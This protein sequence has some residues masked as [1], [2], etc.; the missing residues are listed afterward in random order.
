MDDKTIYMIILFIYLIGMLAIGIWGSKK[1]TSAKSYYTSDRNVNAI[2]TGFSYSSTQLS[3]GSTIGMPATIYRQGYSYMG[4]PMS[5]AAAPW[6]TFLLTGE[7]IRKIS[8][9]V[10]AID[11]ADIFRV[12]FGDRTKILYQI[13]IIVFAIPMI[14]SQFAAAGA[15]V[16]SL[17]GIPY[18]AA[19]PLIAIVLTIYTMTGGMNSVA[20]TDYFQ[21]IIMI[22]GFGI[23]ACLL[24]TEVGGFTAMHTAI[25][26]I[27]PKK[28]TLTGYANPMWVIC[29]IFT[30]SVMMIGGG[31]TQVVRFLIPKDVR[32]LRNALGYST[33]FNVFILITCAIIGLCGISLL[34]GLKATDNMVPTLIG[35]YM[36]PV[37]G[38]ILISAVIAAIMSSVDSILLLCS[39]AAE[40]MYSSYI[41]KSAN[42]EQQLKIGRIITV[43][44][45]LVS[46]LMAFKPFTA[47]QWLVAFS[48]NTWAAAFTVPVLFAV[49]SP[50]TTKEAG[51]WAM[52]G[53]AIS[54]LAWY[55]A[56]YAQ[57][58]TFSNW[59][60]GIWP[61]IFGAF[62][63]LVIILVV[64]QFTDPIDQ[65]TKDIFYL[66]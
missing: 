4:T 58:N 42:V 9:R 30:W 1:V 38:G 29:C 44:V 46:M 33:F 49:W 24:L 16:T 55:A 22:F 59:P 28:L 13:L 6:F 54:A 62:V 51:F 8:E 45:A 50:G 7:R 5:A 52:L 32:T 61:G 63:S 20:M 21:A 39:A 25:A 17:T 60:F 3:S 47:I 65:K 15:S 23:L 37:L 2:V 14:I 11:Y 48:F 36:N 12:R 56:G 41:N 57:Y 34:P 26:A 66:E 27:D 40:G 18:T 31:I 64:S 35:K 43:V 10:D 53:G 19:L